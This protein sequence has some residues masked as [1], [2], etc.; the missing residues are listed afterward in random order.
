MADIIIN[1]GTSIQTT[2]N[3][4]LAN[5]RILLNPGTYQVDNIITVNKSLTLIANVAGTY[6]NV[7]LNGT[8]YAY[9]LNFA[10]NNIVI[11]GLDIDN[12][13][14]N[15]AGG[16]GYV[17]NTVAISNLV[18]QNSKIHHFRRAFVGDTGL[19]TGFSL[20]NSQFYNFQYTTVEI[21]NAK[22]VV[23][24]Y[25]WFL[26][27]VATSGGEA[28]ITFYCKADVGTSDISYNYVSGCRCGIELSA[29]SPVAASIG[30]ILVSHNTIDGGLTGA[31]PAN[32]SSPYYWVRYGV[33]L[34]TSGSNRLEGANINF[35]DNLISRCV[36]QPIYGGSK[37]LISNLVVKNCL[38]FNNY[39]YYWPTQGRTSKE[40]FGV[41]DGRRIQQVPHYSSINRQENR[42]APV[43]RNTRTLVGW[44]DATD[45]Q[46]LSMVDCIDRDPCYSLVGTTPPEFYTLMP[47]SPAINNASDHTNIGA[48]QG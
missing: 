24:K 29:S 14:G 47:N 2:I 17:H 34:W 20:L 15:V 32:I 18:I 16:A 1:P 23:I 40:S 41:L 30:S 35:R 19:V 7:R 38:F 6:P 31:Y 28:P 26:R 36:L 12:T 42:I 13:R 10:A 22:D 4:A 5:D 48:W 27:Q 33:S 21:D 45:T 43:A 37:F 44:E 11:D 25:N 46:Y 39:W 8:T 9:I 3:A